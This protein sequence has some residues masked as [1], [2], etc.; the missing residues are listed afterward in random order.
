MLQVAEGLE[1]DVEAEDGVP[2]GEAV[3]GFAAMFSD[4]ATAAGTRSELPVDIVDD[5]ESG[6]AQ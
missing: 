2:G 1:E 5:V 4:H 3:D 6:D